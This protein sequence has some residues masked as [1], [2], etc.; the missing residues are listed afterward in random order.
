MY[1]CKDWIVT[2]IDKRGY[3]VALCLPNI[4]I[5]SCVKVSFSTTF[6]MSWAKAEDEDPYIDIQLQIFG[7]GFSFYK[8]KFNA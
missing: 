7:F 4:F 1:L 3:E 2:D 6:Y 8:E 5:G